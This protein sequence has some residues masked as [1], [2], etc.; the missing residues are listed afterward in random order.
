MPIS[1]VNNQGS[2]IVVFDD[3]GKEKKRMSGPNRHRRNCEIQQTLSMRIDTTQPVARDEES[4]RWHDTL[5][6]L[7]IETAAELDSL[8]PAILLSWQSFAGTGDRTFARLNLI[9]TGQE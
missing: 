5:K 1:D 7:Q 3:H 4:L 9:P 2:W 6:R 8:I